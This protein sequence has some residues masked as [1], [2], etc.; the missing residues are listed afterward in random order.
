MGTELPVID[1][2]R[3]RLAR[4]DGALELTIPGEGSYSGVSL[5]RAFP[6]S[7]PDRFWG[8]VDSD[9]NEIGVISD[10]DQLDP[11]SRAVA[12]EELERR[13]FIPVVQRV[14]RTKEDFGS[15]IW[16]VETDRGPRTFTVR[17][18][19]DSIVELGASRILLVDVDG[20]RFEFPNIHS[21]DA[22]SYDLILRSQ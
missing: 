6:L 18:M 3:A 20:N 19:K 17:N 21:L 10:P 5:L 12:T 9:G 14:V 22:K 2:T 11:D 13:Y 7:D 15:I 1:A 8:L 4:V 16:T